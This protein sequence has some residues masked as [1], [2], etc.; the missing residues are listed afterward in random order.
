[1]A[2]PICYLDEERVS[3]DAQINSTTIIECTCNQTGRLIP[4]W[5]INNSLLRYD[6]LPTRMSIIDDNLSIIPVIE[7]D[8]GTIFQCI[9]FTPDFPTG[10]R[11]K[12]IV[13]ESSTNTTTAEVTENRIHTSSTAK[14]QHHLVSA[15]TLY[16]INIFV[17]IV[18]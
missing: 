14:K 5:R 8:N 9:F 10:T 4:Y 13:Q 15:I 17:I 12:L 18:L 16:I 7:S 6:E 2:Y 3:V 1:M 11:T